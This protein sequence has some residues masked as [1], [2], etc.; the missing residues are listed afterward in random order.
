MSIDIRKVAVYKALF[1]QINIDCEKNHEQVVP[2]SDIS[3]YTSQILNID[4]H[5]VTEAQQIATEIARQAKSLA[6]FASKIVTVGYH[7]SPEDVENACLYAIGI[8]TVG[9]KE[10]VHIEWDNRSLL[11]TR[12]VEEE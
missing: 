11:I 10:N 1:E 3:Y 2:F 4:S 12:Q 5:S 8:T 6:P 9:E 7:L